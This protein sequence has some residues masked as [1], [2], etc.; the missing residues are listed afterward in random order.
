MKTENGKYILESFRIPGSTFSESREENTFLLIGKCGWLLIAQYLEIKAQI[1]H[2]PGEAQTFLV[3][4]TDR[5]TPRIVIKR[6]L[7]NGMMSSLVCNSKLYRAALYN[8]PTH[9]LMT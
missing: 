9:S 6:T 8:N 5:I 2:C 1:D 3:L 7:W 4:R